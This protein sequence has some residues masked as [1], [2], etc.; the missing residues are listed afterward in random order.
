MKNATILA[1]YA[2]A[3]FALITASICLC[4]IAIHEL[5]RGRITSVIWMIGALIVGI[6]GS[7]PFMLFIEF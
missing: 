6:I 7:Y 5:W 2:L 1:P 3:A 4:H